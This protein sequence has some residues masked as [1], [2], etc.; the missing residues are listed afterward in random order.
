M[1]LLSDCGEHDIKVQGD[2]CQNE[3]G[4][5]PMMA[6]LSVF[7]G[8]IHPSLGELWGLQLWIFILVATL[9]SLFLVGYLI[10]GTRVGIQLGLAISRTKALKRTKNPV[11]PRDVAA[12]LRSKPL[13]HLWDE[14]SDTL[15]ELRRAGSGSAQLSEV[16]AT[17]PAEMFFTRDVLVDSRLLDDFTR[18]L[19]GVLTGLGIIGTF[20]GLLEG[21]SRFDAT[22]S[23]TAVAGLKSLL[24]GVAHA[25][26]VSAIAIGC[27]MVVLFISRLALAIFYQQVESLSHTIDALYTTGAGEEYLSRLVHSS[28]MSGAH[29]AQLK[30]AL[31]DD[32]TKLLN[33]LIDRQIAAQA[34]NSRSLG[35]HISEALNSSL[36]EPI[37]R[38]NEAIEMTR[39]GNIRPSNGR[40]EGLLTGF[41]AKF[42]DTVGGQM[43]GNNEHLARSVGALEQPMSDKMRKFVNDLRKLVTDEQRKS[44]RTTDDAIAAVLQQLETE[45]AQLEGVVAQ[46]R[47][48]DGQ[49]QQYLEEVHDSLSI[50]FY[51]FGNQ[52]TG[53]I[54]DSLCD[55]DHNLRNGVL[56]LTGVVQ[57][58]RSVLASRKKG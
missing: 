55:A 56:H 12:V 44:E 36:A 14:Y 32:L 40:L 16:R 17:V 6:R 27:A 13:N 42:E 53:V 15:H 46:L 2:H 18:H 19:P 35:R 34:E 37:K 3:E 47:P 26:T 49:S 20:A 51:T 39:R 45:L 58:F 38:I 5:L 30:K 52:A 41:V 9:T 21:L 28:E 57:E 23:T 22:S 43:R 33:N 54:R 10:Q 31:V 29:A 7:L 1:L 25:F 11:D 50:A 48:A 8:K 4:Y 24:T